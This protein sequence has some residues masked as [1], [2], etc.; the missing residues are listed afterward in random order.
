MKGSSEKADSHFSIIR[1]KCAISDSLVSEKQE[2]EM[3][4]CLAKQDQHS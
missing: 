1:D 2:L 3:P 4:S